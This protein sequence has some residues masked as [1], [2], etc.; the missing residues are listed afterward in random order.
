MKTYIFAQDEQIGKTMDGWSSRSIDSKTGEIQLEGRHD[1]KFDGTQEYLKLT[2]R[3]E[4]MELC[5]ILEP[6]A[7]V[8][9]RPYSGNC[10][11]RIEDRCEFRRTDGKCTADLF[12]NEHCPNN[13]G[14]CD[15]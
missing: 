14:H 6:V 15:E 2:L 3:I 12:D 11:M 7:L 1:I 10:L 13:D 5:R 4:K 9:K 8:D